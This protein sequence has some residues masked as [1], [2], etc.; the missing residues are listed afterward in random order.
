MDVISIKLGVVVEKI[1]IDEISPFFAAESGYDY[2]D[3]DDDLDSQA[4]SPTG[5]VTGRDI[6]PLSGLAVSSSPSFRSSSLLGKSKSKPA[7]LARATDDVNFFLETVDVASVPN[8]TPIAF[9]NDPER[10]HALAHLRKQMMLS[11][12]D[13]CML[14]RGEFNHQA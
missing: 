12:P 11:N 1:D 5:I 14:C 7:H 6:D 8:D 10:Q 2:D 3:S 4:S 13:E 9:L